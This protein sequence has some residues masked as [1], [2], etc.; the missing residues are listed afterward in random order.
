MEKK[1]MVR[2]RVGLITERGRCGE[3]LCRDRVGQGAHSAI[4]CSLRLERSSVVGRLASAV[5]SY[6]LNC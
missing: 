3:L 1:V 4:H 6:R 5:R 2:G